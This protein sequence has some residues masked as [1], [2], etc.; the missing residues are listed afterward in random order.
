MGRYGKWASYNASRGRCAS[1]VFPYSGGRF[2][3]RTVRGARGWQ[4]TWKPWNVPPSMRAVMMMVAAVGHTARPGPSTVVSDRLVASRRDFYRDERATAGKRVPEK[5][6]VES[7]IRRLPRRARK[8]RRQ[9]LKSQVISSG[10]NWEANSGKQV[11]AVTDASESRSAEKTPVVAGSQRGPISERACGSK[12]AR[13]AETATTDADGPARLATENLPKLEPTAD[14]TM[15]DDC[16]EA[17]IPRTQVNQCQPPVVKPDLRTVAPATKIGSSLDDLRNYKIPKIRRQQPPVEE[18]DSDISRAS[19]VSQRSREREEQEEHRKGL[20][21]SQSRSPLSGRSSSRCV[22]DRIIEDMNKAYPRVPSGYISCGDGCPLQNEAGNEFP[23]SPTMRRPLE[24]DRGISGKVAKL[25]TLSRMPL[26]SHVRQKQQTK[27]VCVICKRRVISDAGGQDTCIRCSLCKQ[28]TK[29]QA[30]VKEKGGKERLAA[31]EPDT[32]AKLH[33]RRASSD[34]EN[35][36]RDA[37]T[38]TCPLSSKSDDRVKVDTVSPQGKKHRIVSKKRARKAYLTK[39][40]ISSSNESCSEDDGCSATATGVSA[41]QQVEAAAS[42]SVQPQQKDEN[43]TSNESQRNVTKNLPPKDDSQNSEKCFKASSTGSKVSRAK[44]TLQKKTIKGSN[45]EKLRRQV[46]KQAW[47]TAKDTDDYLRALSEMPKGTDPMK[48]LTKKDKKSE[49]YGNCESVKD[50]HADTK[51]ASL[52]QTDV[53]SDV[54]GFTSD[55]LISSGSPALLVASSFSLTLTDWEGLKNESIDDAESVSVGGMTGNVAPTSTLV[56]SDSGPPG[57]K[58]GDLPTGPE[59]C[60][61]EAGSPPIMISDFSDD[62]LK[63]DCNAPNKSPMWLPYSIHF[64]DDG[65]MSV[66]IQDG[67]SGGGREIGFSAKKSGAL[68][69]QAQEAVASDSSDVD[70]LAALTEC[71]QKISTT[72]IPEGDADKTGLSK[73]GA[74][75]AVPVSALAPSRAGDSSISVDTSDTSGQHTAHGNFNKPA[76]VGK[77]AHTGCSGSSY[78]SLVSPTAPAQSSL[79]TAADPK[80]SCV[81]ISYTAQGAIGGGCVPCAEDPALPKD[82]LRLS[83]AA[84]VESC[85]A[86]GTGNDS[87]PCSMDLDLPTFKSLSAIPINTNAAAMQSSCTTGGNVRKSSLPNAGHLASDTADIP[88]SFDAISLVDNVFGISRAATSISDK[89]CADHHGM[90]HGL[91]EEYVQK[92][93]IFLAALSECM[94]DYRETLVSTLLPDGFVKLKRMVQLVW[95]MEAKLGCLGTGRVLDLDK[96]VCSLLIEHAGKLSGTSSLE[97]DLP[98]FMSFEV[99]SEPHLP[100]R[101]NPPCQEV[102][103]DG[104]AAN[105][106]MLLPPSGAITEQGQVAGQP[107][108]LLGSAVALTA[109]STVHQAATD[110]TSPLEQERLSTGISGPPRSTTGMVP[111]DVLRVARGKPKNLDGASSGGLSESTNKKE[112]NSVCAGAVVAETAVSSNPNRHRPLSR[113]MA[114]QPEQQQLAQARTMPHSAYEN[115]VLGSRMEVDP[116]APNKQLPGHRSVP[117]S[118]FASWQRQTVGGTQSLAQQNSQTPKEKLSQTCSQKDV[119]RD[120]PQQNRRPGQQSHSAANRPSQVRQVRFELR[121]PPPLM[122]VGP[123][124]HTVHNQGLPAQPSSMNSRQREELG[125]QMT[126]YSH[127]NAWLNAYSLPENSQGGAGFPY[128]CARPSQLSPGYVPPVGQSTGPTSGPVSQLRYVPQTPPVPG[129][130]DAQGQ[131]QKRELCL[132]Q[133][134]GLQTA[135]IRTLNSLLALSSRTS[136]ME[137]EQSYGPQFSPLMPP[138]DRAQDTSQ[139]MDAELLKAEKDVQLQLKKRQY[140]QLLMQRLHGR[141]IAAGQQQGHSEASEP[142]QLSERER[143][144]QQQIRLALS[145]LSAKSTSQSGQQYQAAYGSIQQLQQYLPAEQLCESS[146]QPRTSMSNSTASISAQS[147]SSESSRF[148]R[149]WTSVSQWPYPYTT[150]QEALQRWKGQQQ[151]EASEPVTRVPPGAATQTVD[152]HRACLFVQPQQTVTVRQQAPVH[153]VSLE[154]R[155]QNLAARSDASSWR[156]RVGIIVKSTT[157]CQSLVDTEASNG[158]LA[159]NQRASSIGLPSQQLLREPF[160]KQLLLGR[161]LNAAQGMRPQGPPPPSQ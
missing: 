24:D 86:D 161:P 11:I 131:F 76:H 106:G 16:T 122:Y 160:V 71:L 119:P 35:R 59:K 25:A 81:E 139:A 57:G 153:Q 103:E 87:P 14:C 64:E 110:V 116:K 141:Q 120:I 36:E 61:A 144:L 21:R 32:P 100:T 38:P 124:Q 40:V 56:S 89:G 77:H 50:D 12:K 84:N 156:N 155:N 90:L 15:P 55:S 146:A 79:C 8:R 41:S 10:E 148:V 69:E 121:E 23:R 99:C 65:A 66:T 26:S 52:E 138:P 82:Q 113:E 44:P 73:Q 105:S 45:K 7:Q 157:P 37:K 147:T 125:R 9:K 132:Q 135:G 130:S 68:A 95:R 134:Q 91:L 140:L 1:G 149:P 101:T 112:G 49:A 107:D 28:I 117:G 80:E 150:C 97:S 43:T 3:V 17:A 137:T 33:K 159:E 62:E 63:E 109:E 29:E 93:E 72:G 54:C 51:T 128:S 88:A 123:R 6:P 13:S 115:S 27:K 108:T 98:S 127:N 20:T 39:P 2:G 126:A 96:G 18:H 46:M 154:E 22:V 4:P 60:A 85:G 158:H 145:M 19:P 111:D 67:A 58:N 30:A 151:E 136:R 53:L 133:Q 92:M 48:T 34:V 74:P 114:T 129:T 102:A 75:V 31:S 142:R 118:F 94:S 5:Q 152:E 42:P 47:K 104:E 83:A 143:Y 70:H 78:R